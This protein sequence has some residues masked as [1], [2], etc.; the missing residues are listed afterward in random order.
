MD[1]TAPDST[2]ITDLLPLIQIKA[3]ARAKA[4]VHGIEPEAA[5]SQE[6]EMCEACRAAVTRTYREMRGLGKDEA[7]A[8]EAALRVLALR[9]PEKSPATR[10][11]VLAEWLDTAG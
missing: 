1:F 2:A 4:M 11:S 5:M 6:L 3:K 9:H 10:V 7:I 8:F